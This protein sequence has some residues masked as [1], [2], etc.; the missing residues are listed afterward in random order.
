MFSKGRHF[1]KPKFLPVLD[2]DEDIRPEV[3]AKERARTLFLRAQPKWNYLKR[4]GKVFDG[5]KV[6]KKVKKKNERIDKYFYM[7][8]AEI[9]N[10]LVW[11]DLKPCNKPKNWTYTFF[12]KMEYSK[13]HPDKFNF[14]KP[15]E[16]NIEYA[17]DAFRRT[18]KDGSFF[19]REIGSII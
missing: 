2:K 4:D 17:D 19:T 15:Y 13:P 6:Y 1:A 14:Y 7:T 8:M 18:T 10:S 5:D 9:R 12:P 11:R 16:K 3:L